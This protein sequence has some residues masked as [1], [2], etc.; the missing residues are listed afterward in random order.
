MR[1]E[2]VLNERL[3]LIGKELATLSEAFE[4]VD[5]SLSEF[6]DMQEEFRALKVCLGKL[7]PEFGKEFLSAMKKVA[8]K[9]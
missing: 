7:Q 3:K 2:K 9:S 8:R 1:E 5:K 4:R 6:Q